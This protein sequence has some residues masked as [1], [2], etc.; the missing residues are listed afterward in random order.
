MKK[1]SEMT[2]EELQ[3]YALS[4][5]NENES[6]KAEKQTL[7]EQNNELSSLNKNLQKRNNDLFMQ[8]EQQTNEDSTPPAKEEKPVE[9]CEDFARKLI[10]G[11]K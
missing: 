11:E 7:T 9:S 6:L 2:M 8:V 10:L 5:T 1:I 3:D 4:I